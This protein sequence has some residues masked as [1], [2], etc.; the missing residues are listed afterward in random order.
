MKPAW[1]MRF[2]NWTG[3]DTMILEDEEVMIVERERVQR[4]L[5]ILTIHLLLANYFGTIEA[6]SH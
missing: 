5:F 6:T 4:N 2:I 1:L 3:R